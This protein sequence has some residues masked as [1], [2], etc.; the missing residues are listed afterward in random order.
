M[1]KL[2]KQYKIR[3]LYKSGYTHDIWVK[4][5]SIDRGTYKWEEVSTK[6]QILKL[7]ADEI[8]AVFQMNERYRFA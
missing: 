5:F 3:I 2:T 6:N 7:G 8:A 4:T 1:F